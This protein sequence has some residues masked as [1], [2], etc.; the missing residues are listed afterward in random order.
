MIDKNTRWP[1]LREVFHMW[2]IFHKDNYTNFKFFLTNFI[3]TI[4]CL[5]CKIHANM[6]LNKNPIR[7]KNIVEWWIDFHN[8]VNIMLWKDTISEDKALELFAKKWWIFLTEQ[9]KEN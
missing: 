5:E 6:N 8:K 9:A 4:P 3:G 7:P 2:T 1:I